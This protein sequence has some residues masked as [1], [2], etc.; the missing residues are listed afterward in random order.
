MLNK[1]QEDEKLFFSTKKELKID[2]VIYRPSICYKVPTLARRSLEKYEADRVVTFYPS[3]VR[4]V[5][6]GL[7]P[8]PVEQVS[9]EVS[10]VVNTID[11]SKTAKRRSR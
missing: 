3:K 6:G 11:G 8:V 2:G 1:R 10:S 4:F 9:A 5:N 7:A